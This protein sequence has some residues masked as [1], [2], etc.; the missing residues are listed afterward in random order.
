MFCEHLTK[1]PKILSKLQSFWNPYLSRFKRMTD[2]DGLIH[3]KQGKVVQVL[4]IPFYAP[5]F[6]YGTTSG[7][8]SRGILFTHP[9]RTMKFC[10]VHRSFAAR[11]VLPIRFLTSRSSITALLSFLRPPDGSINATPS[12]ELTSTF[13][14]NA[15]STS[16]L[17]SIPTVLH[18]TLLLGNTLTASFVFSPTSSASFKPSLNSRLQ[19]LCSSWHLAFYLLEMP[20]HSRT[21]LLLHSKTLLHALSSSPGH[22]HM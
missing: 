20:F 11:C 12:F 14:E 17:R 19:S 13:K 9:P 1:D 5:K 21:S 18:Y 16:F 6:T 3:N 4:L 8:M 22:H 10:M 7:D 15:P 2:P